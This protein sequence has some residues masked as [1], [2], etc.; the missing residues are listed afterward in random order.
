MNLHGPDGDPT[1]HLDATEHES[2]TKDFDPV[3]FHQAVNEMGEL[4]AQG[5]EPPSEELRAVLAVLEK[6]DDEAPRSCFASTVTCERLRGGEPVAADEIADIEGQVIA[7]HPRMDELDNTDSVD[8]FL[9]QSEHM[10]EVEP[11]EERRAP[12]PTGLFGLDL[13]RYCGEHRGGP[14][15]VLATEEA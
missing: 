15:A 5:E 3:K 13:C 14:D 8:E 2:P 6:A 10:L 4:Q 1:R 9:E 7:K 11:L 12:A